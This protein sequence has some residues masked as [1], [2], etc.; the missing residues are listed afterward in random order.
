LDEEP[1]LLAILGLQPVEH[2]I[3]RQTLGDQVADVD[4]SV[5][6]FYVV[7]GLGEP[8]HRAA[9]ALRAIMPDEG[10]LADQVD[11]RRLSAS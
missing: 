8:S 11:R 10:R 6:R 9:V 2:V 3:V 1:H 7:R 5:E 4:Q